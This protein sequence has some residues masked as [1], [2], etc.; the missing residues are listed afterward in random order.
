MD[1]SDSH[2][3]RS[4]GGGQQRKTRSVGQRRPYVES[5]SR[6]VSYWGNVEEVSLLKG[7]KVT[8]HFSKCMVE[9]A[10]QWFALTHMGPRTPP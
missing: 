3:R 6:A 10:N 4:H 8:C 7:A 1:T 5:K 2:Q 9:N